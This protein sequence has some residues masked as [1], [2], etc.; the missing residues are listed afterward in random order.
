MEKQAF[1]GYSDLS[2]QPISGG[3]LQYL[4]DSFAMRCNG[5][6][7]SY[8][9]LSCLIAHLISSL[10]TSPIVSE[11]RILTNVDDRS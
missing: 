1:C 10:L 11:V 3:G 8:R 4:H 9:V 6:C 2:H 7:E 5:S